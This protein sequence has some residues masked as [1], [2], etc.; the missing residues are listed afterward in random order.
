[1]VRGNTSRHC[2]TKT[3]PASIPSARR[4]APPSAAMSYVLD[5]RELVHKLPFHHFTA[6]GL[7]TSCVL[8]ALT[9]ASPGVVAAG[10]CLM[11][12]RTYTAQNRTIFENTNIKEAKTRAIITVGVILAFIPAA[13][14]GLI[15]GFRGGLQTLKTIEAWAENGQSG[16]RAIGAPIM[17]MDDSLTMLRREAVTANDVGA[18]AT[19]AT[20][21]TAVTEAMLH[22]SGSIEFIQD[23]ESLKW[24][25]T[26][27]VIYVTSMTLLMLLLIS[28]LTTSVVPIIAHHGKTPVSRW[29]KRAPG[30][31]TPEYFVRALP[32][33][34][35]IYCFLMTSVYW[36][37]SVIG[38][39]VCYSYE[40]MVEFVVPEN[41]QLY[42]VCPR[43]GYELGEYLQDLHADNVKL[44]ETIGNVQDLGGAYASS[45]YMTALNAAMTSFGA[46]FGII[47]EGLGSCQPMSDTI[48]LA[49]AQV[50]DEV[51]LGMQM[52][53]AVSFGLTC[54][55]MYGTL[56]RW[57][58]SDVAKELAQDEE[59]SL[60]S[61][62]TSES[63][64]EARSKFGAQKKTP[65][66][67]GKEKEKKKKDKGA[68]K[69]RKE[70]KEGKVAEDGS[71]HVSSSSSEEE[72]AGATASPSV[73]GTAQQESAAPATSPPDDAAPREIEMQDVMNDDE[74]STAAD[75]D[76]AEEYDSGEEEF[77]E[78]DGRV[79][80]PSD[81]EDYIDDVDETTVVETP[82]DE[83]P[84]VSA[85]VEPENEGSDVAEAPPPTVATPSSSSRVRIVDPRTKQEVTFEPARPKPKSD[86]T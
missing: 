84:P 48:E 5:M 45:Q 31:V 55:L 35:L 49:T 40:A 38:A 39:E 33:F 70:A 54:L 61:K 23:L 53:T 43:F 81:L 6:Y 26:F 73:E 10:I 78:D 32:L 82:A 16:M 72:G 75:D 42:F 79:D 22:H 18:T 66:E 28:L 12:Y 86:D 24:V 13:L 11:Y 7:R 80:V 52:V 14:I 77:F 27:V 62:L 4:G 57:F 9:Y 85:V 47:D 2:N 64:I 3:T 36:P 58:G 29:W 74:P 68:K 1:M 20:A 65:A 21:L 51:M 25:K 63:L 30:R 83:E 71:T 8:I 15:E 37:V 17:A 50:C 44:K 56:H 59:Q 60:F 41:V 46:D 67:Q 69:K 76:G 34:T 19:I